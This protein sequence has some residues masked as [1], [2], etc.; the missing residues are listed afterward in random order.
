MRKLYNT[1]DQ[2]TY[3]ELEVHHAE[4][5]NEAYD[6]RLDN[7]NLLTLCVYHHKMADRGEI[8]L[9]DIKR[10]IEEQERVS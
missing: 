10:I 2:F 5:L 6:K 7:N 1:I 8:Q 3:D 9:N 4:K